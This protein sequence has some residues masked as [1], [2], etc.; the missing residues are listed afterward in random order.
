MNKTKR[1][2]CDISSELHAAAKIITMIGDPFLDE[3]S[4][5][6][7]ADTGSA[8]YGVSC[9]LERLCE[10]LDELEKENYQ[11]KKAAGLVEMKGEK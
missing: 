5:S 6:T 8:L 7:Q 2:I 10:D 9:Y 4:L 11:L 3:N 1:D